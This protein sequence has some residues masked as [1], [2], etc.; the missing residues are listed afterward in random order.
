MGETESEAEPAY[1]DV[2]AWF[3]GYFIQVFGDSLGYRSGDGIPWCPQWWRHPSVAIRLDALWRS[4]E[5]ARHGGGLGISFW[6]LDH[7]DPHIR[8]LTSERGPFRH[9]SIEHGHRATE[10][11]PVEAPEDNGLLFGDPAV[12]RNVRDPKRP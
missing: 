3:D 1:G 5:V 7:A 8:A 12:R 9:C 2:M 11:L 10:S 6:L 4:W